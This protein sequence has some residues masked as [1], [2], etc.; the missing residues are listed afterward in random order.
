[1]T[2]RLWA[3]ATTEE[4]AAAVGAGGSVLAIQP[5]GAALV[6]HWTDALAAALDEIARFA[7]PCANDPAGAVA[8]AV[9][10]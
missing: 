6:S 5:I 2:T 8:A 7:F 9:A 3:E 1:V 10:S 4:I